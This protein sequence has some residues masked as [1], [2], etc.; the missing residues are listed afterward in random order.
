[1]NNRKIY[2][3]QAAFLERNKTEK[4]SKITIHE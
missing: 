2:K 3:D 4:S 1:M